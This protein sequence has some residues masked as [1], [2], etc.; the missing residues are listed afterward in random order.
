MVGKFI[1]SFI[2]NMVNYGVSVKIIFYDV[3][4]LEV[5]LFIWYE[6]KYK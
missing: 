2:S 1:D 4:L 5:E 6:I 3:L